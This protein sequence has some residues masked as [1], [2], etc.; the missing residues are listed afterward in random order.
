MLRI[1]LII[2]VI[3]GLAVAGL[4]IAL[5]KDKI[6]VLVKD[7]DDQKKEKEEKTRALTK[8]QSDLKNTQAELKTTK[9]N[10]VAAN[11][12]K[13]KAEAQ[14]ADLEK[15][16]L[17]L[18]DTLNKTKGDLD[19]SRNELAAWKALGTSVDDVGKRLKAYNDVVGQRDAFAV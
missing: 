7:R 8:S 16:N 3:A 11:D 18:T 4:N 9:D 5:V 1:S 2:A 12:A 13:D 10:L 14:A 17:V 19:N 15:K 6:T